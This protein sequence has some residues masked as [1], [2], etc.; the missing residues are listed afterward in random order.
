MHEKATV[1]T[2]ES[3]FTAGFVYGSFLFGISQI[4]SP[5]PLAID[6]EGG[7]FTF[8]II[9]L[10]EVRFTILALLMLL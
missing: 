1:W 6:G 4:S 3:F 7:P 2:L 5:P 10:R 8:W 9:A